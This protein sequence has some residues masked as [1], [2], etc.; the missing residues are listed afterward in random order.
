VSKSSATQILYTP[1]RDI[2][3]DG[4]L[5]ALAA[6]YKCILDCR[7]KQ[8]GGPPTAPDDAMKGSND[9]RARHILPERP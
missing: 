6:V 9:D 3:P 8:E 7:R 5:N 1:R 4:E 2:T